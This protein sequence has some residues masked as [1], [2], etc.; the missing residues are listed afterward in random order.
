MQSKD[1]K[2]LEFIATTYATL[3]RPSDSV[4]YLRKADAAGSQNSAL[5]LQLAMIDLRQN[6][7]SQGIQE[8]LDGMK[9]QSAT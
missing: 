9:M 7:T 2:V 4:T 8:M 6:N 1:P 5:K 3:N